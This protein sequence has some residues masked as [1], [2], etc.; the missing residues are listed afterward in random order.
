MMARY[1]RQMVLGEVGQK[2]QRRLLNSR[3]LVVGAGALGS[4][5]ATYLALAGVGTVGLVDGDVVEL[6]NLH[7][8]ILHDSDQV[9][10]LK[11]ESAQR[12]LGALNPDVRVVEHPVFLNRDNTLG[13]FAPYD[14]IVNGSD[15]FPT[16]YL[17]NDAAVLLQKPLV[18][19][20]ILRFEGQLAVF[21]PGLG[22]YR[23]LFP[24]P[25]PLGTVPDCA[26]AGILGAV[27]GVMGSMQAVETLKLL[28]GLSNDNRLRIYDALAGTWYP[29]PFMRD[30]AC[31]VCGDAPT[32]STLIDYENFCGV[33]AGL[34]D[35][36]SGV[37]GEWSV[38]VDEADSLLADPNLLVI[39]V[40]DPREYAAGHIPGA[41]RLNLEDLDAWVSHHADQKT[42]V[43][44]QVGIRSASATEYLRLNQMD[45][46]NLAGGTR[47]WEASG[48]PL[49]QEDAQNT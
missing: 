4:A 31:R 45:A 34:D 13:I 49:S 21:R 6:S 19:A 36:G 16:R 11:T 42:L 28:L 7:R 33:A 3:V 18:D 46:W 27:A 38:T 9:G 30:P 5:A 39:D 2:G 43:V 24:E 22:C 17:V 23:C 44:C 25:P 47:A 8:Q 12:R 20:A 14:V 41:V 10:V 29:V 15:N 37:A 26:V 40:R 1:Q 32:V 35:R 48:R